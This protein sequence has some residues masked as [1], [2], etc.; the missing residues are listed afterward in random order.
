MKI[1]DI[2]VKDA[3]ILNLGVRTKRDVLAEMAAALAKV[4]SDRREASR[5]KDDDED[6]ASSHE[7]ETERGDE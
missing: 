1:M 7:A 3:L 5:S 4:Q 2:L 6:P